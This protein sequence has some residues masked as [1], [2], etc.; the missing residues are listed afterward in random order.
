MSLF[1]SEVPNADIQLSEPQVR[2]ERGHEPLWELQ[3]IDARLN[4]G[5]FTEIADRLCRYFLHSF[6]KYTH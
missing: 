3:E 2:Q 6:R 5:F 1:H 4:K